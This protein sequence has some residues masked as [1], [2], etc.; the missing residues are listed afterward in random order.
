MTLRVVGA[1]LGRTGTM[2]LKVAL[3]KLLGG[4]CYHM[5]ELF[6]HPEHIKD[7][8]AAGKG[9]MP[10]WR[11][12]FAGYR[13]AVDWPMCSFW[14]EIAAVHPD[15]L[16]LLSVRDADSWWQSASETIFKGMQLGAERM[17]EWHA[18][19]RDIMESRFVWPP[20]DEAKTKA[21]YERWNEQVRARAP[22]RRFLEWRASDG[23]EPICKALDL[24]VPNEPFPRVNTR[25]EFLARM[26]GR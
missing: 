2:S 1:G 5:L 25:D 4:P 13:A 6:T 19:V 14:E 20:D 22:R 23:W 26:T 18:M 24:P 7:W 3:E 16:V 21:A 15:A 17:P 9:T 11:R 8:A 12:L 10:D